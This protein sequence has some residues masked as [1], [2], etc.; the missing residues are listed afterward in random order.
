MCFAGYIVYKNQKIIANDIISSI[1]ENIPFMVLFSELKFNSYIIPGKI[2]I[3]L[4][5]PRIR[6]GKHLFLCQK[7]LVPHGRTRCARHHG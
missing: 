4:E 2:D 3:G 7:R 1:I 5:R 6:N